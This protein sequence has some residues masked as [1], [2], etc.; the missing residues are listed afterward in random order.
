[1]RILTWT[2]FPET[3]FLKFSSLS[4][5]EKNKWLLH[6]LKCIWILKQSGVVGFFFIFGGGVVCFLVF[7]FRFLFCFLSHQIVCALQMQFRLSNG[8]LKIGT[9]LAM[10]WVNRTGKNFRNI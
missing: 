4:V 6:V 9:R 3:Y 10:L 7:F 8:C 2:S 1:M 5:F